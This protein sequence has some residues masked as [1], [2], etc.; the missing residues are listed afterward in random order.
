MTAPT[1]AGASVSHTYTAGGTFT[2]TVTVT[3]DDGATDSATRTIAVTNIVSGTV[4]TAAAMV[5]DSDVNDPS[6]PY[7]QN[8]TAASAQ[9][10][11]SPATVGGYLNIVGSGN[12]GRS[13]DVG[14]VSD[15]FKVALADGQTITLQFPDSAANDLD[16]YLYDS[17]KNFLASSTGAE[18]TKTLTANAGEPFYYI[19]VKIT[20]LFG[21]DNYSNYTLFVGQSVSSVDKGALYLSHDFVPGEVVVRFRDD[22]VAAAAVPNMNARA[23]SVG[24][25]PFSGGSGRTMRMG[26]RDAYEKQEAF[27][28]LG[29]AAPVQ[30]SVFAATGLSDDEVQE[31]MDTLSVVMALRQ[32]S[33][34][35]T[36]D[37]NYILRPAA[38]T[39]NDPSWAS[40]WHYPFINL[41]DAWDTTT[42]KRLGDRGGGGYRRASH[43]PGSFRTAGYRLRLRQFHLPLPG[44]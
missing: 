9:E 37:P 24:L 14:D 11:T 21:G 31:K 23:E 28:R 1:G 13:R 18:N 41:D 27:Q 17:G 30:G 43:P 40:Q 20:S 4:S 8:D 42:G 36:A 32:R 6:A 26:F 5:F 29:I 15:F 16:L 7:T 12:A 44:R 3:D 10:I 2:A 39:P 25:Q 22:A 34:V 33:D 38:T 35:L 19:E